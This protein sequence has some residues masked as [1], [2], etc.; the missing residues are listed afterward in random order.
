[1][2]YRERMDRQRHG[3]NTDS[4]RRVQYGTQMGRERDMSA[5]ITR[6]EQKEPLPFL[7]EGLAYVFFKFM[8]SSS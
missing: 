1:M 8:S 3:D 7:F 6:G 2:I 5:W 4:S